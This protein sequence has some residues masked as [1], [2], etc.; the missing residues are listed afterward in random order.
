M[1]RFPLFILLVAV[2][3]VGCSGKTEEP[4]PEP[5]IVTEEEV[6]T[7]EP[8]PEEAGPFYSDDRGFRAVTF[9]V[10]GGFVPSLK[11][12]LPEKEKFAENLSAQM[13]KA[14]FWDIDHRRDVR[15][16]DVVRLVYK[17]TRDRFKVR[18]YGVEYKSLR[19]EKTFR[20]FFF[21]EKDRKYPEYFSEAGE[22]V[23]KRMKNPPLKHYDDIVSL[24]RAGSKSNTGVVF[25]VPRGTK[26]RMPFPATVERVNWDMDDLGLSVQVAYSGTDLHA[27]FLHLSAISEE[28]EPDATLSTGTVFARTGL[29]GK[30]KVP[31]LVYRLFK[32]NGDEIEYVDPFGFHGIET[33]TLQTS[34]YKDFVLV[35]HRVLALMNKVRLGD[36]PDQEPAH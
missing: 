18:L 16:G 15:K 14:L 23:S 24:F 19:F 30:V 32:K 3:L 20:Y 22:A 33:Y 8:T 4:T 9:R 35:K 21:W 29:T 27:Q 34:A 28:V 6:M 12:A 26:V 10:D 36:E 31:Q 13:I 2:L 5:V 17:P 25:R 1:K 11:K 7:P